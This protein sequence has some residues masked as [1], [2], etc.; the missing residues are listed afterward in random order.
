M[1][2]STHPLWYK[3][4]GALL[5]CSEHKQGSPY[6]CLPTGHVFLA[7]LCVLLLNCL[8]MN[9]PRGKPEEP[10]WFEMSL[11]SQPGS[12]PQGE[13]GIPLNVPLWLFCPKQN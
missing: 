8:P 3:W 5:L 6:P 1:A 4:S 11:V 9:C 7:A 10:Q 13:D 2:F 12:K